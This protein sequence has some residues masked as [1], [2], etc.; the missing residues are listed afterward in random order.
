MGLSPLFW[1]VPVVQA[2]TLTGGS[3]TLS[4]SRPSQTSVS[5]TTQFSNVTL[6][7]IK[8]IKVVFSTAATGGTVPTG[9]T[10]TS[11]T[12]G[13]TSN[14]VPTPGS[15]S[16]DAATNGTVKITYA[17]GETPAASS[18]RTVILT[19]ITNGSTV[20]TQYFVQFSTYN[21]IDCASSAVDSGSITFVYTTGQAVSLTVDPSISFTVNSVASGTVNGANITA[22]STAT[23]IPL[24]AVSSSANAIAAH[25]LTVTTN[26]GTGYTIYARYTAVPTSGSNTINDCSGTNASPTAFSA[27]GTEAFGYTTDDATLGTGTP[28][29]FI[30]DKWAKFTTSNLE[31]AYNAAAVSSQTTRV[32]YEVGVAGTTE[33]GSYTT[34]VVL[35]ATPTY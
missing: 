7:A 33:A 19:G 17:T 23:T 5:Y 24:G 16:V 30:S 10:T 20:D 26:A 27:A 3:E 14:Y 1:S 32:G 18:S 22:A 4:D 35:T 31:V 34:T 15:W 13:G 8:C 9:M 21:N 2:A 11:A 6:S 12:F 28:G 25:D 29:R